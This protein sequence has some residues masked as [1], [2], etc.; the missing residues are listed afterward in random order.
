MRF[1]ALAMISTFLCG[2]QSP[3]QGMPASTAARILEQ[4]TWGPTA[5]TIADLQSKGFDAWFAAQVAAP[6]TTYPNQPMLNSSGTGFTN[7]SGVQVQFFENALYNPDQLRQRV[8]FALS[9]IWVVSHEGVV[10]YAAAFPPLLNIF[11]ND[12]FGTYSQLMK[13]VTLNPAMGEYLNMVNNHKSTSTSS[14]NENYGRELMQLFTLGL[15]V[16]EPNGNPVLD[17]NN[18]PIPTYSPKTVTEMSAALTGWTYAPTPTGGV[19]PNLFSPMVAQQSQHDVSAKM[20]P[21][22]YPNGTTVN[23]SLPANQTAEQDLEGALAGI[24]ANPTLAPF[25][26]KQLIQHLVTSNPSPAYIQDVVGVFNTTGGNLQKV[27]YEILTYSEARNGDSGVANEAGNFGHL[28]EPV[29]LV[30]NLLRALNGT[31][32]DSSTIYNYTSNLGQSLFNEPSVFSYF[33]PQYTVATGP[34]TA[35]LAPEFQLHTTQTAVSRA[36]YIYSAIYNGQL[37]GSTMFSIANFVTAAS[38]S[39]AALETLISNTFFHGLMSSSLTTAIN[40]ALSDPKTNTATLKAQAALYV[41][42]TS[43]E[44]QIIH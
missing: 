1:A 19:S 41:A 32:F 27:V 4:A 23:V 22:T 36:N 5:A 2:A 15:N 29:L 6:I 7:L 20:I 18:N 21:F 38:T 43:S 11:Q 17:A 34:T 35:A 3:P 14:A 30:E 42:L 12:A 37:D 28:R 44:F 39:N 9:E 16:L 8:A 24:Y 13:D 26:V 33:S 25:V 40:T 31:V 10:S